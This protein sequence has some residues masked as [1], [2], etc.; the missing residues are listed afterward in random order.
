MTGDDLDLLI[1]FTKYR[2]KGIQYSCERYSLLQQ[3]IFKSF[4]SH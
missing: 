1:V 2:K 3:V 4:L